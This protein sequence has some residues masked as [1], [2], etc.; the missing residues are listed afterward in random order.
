MKKQ[1]LLLVLCIVAT[2]LNAQV[3]TEYFSTAATGSNLE[4]YNEWYVSAKSADANGESPK[5]QEETLFH[6]GYA[7]SN[8]G[9]VAVLD[10]LVGKVSA[11]QRISTKLITIGSDTLRPVVGQKMYA[12]FL[13]QVFPNSYSSYRDFF[14]WEGSTTSSM[15]RG[16]VFAKVS[17]AKADLQFAVSKNSSSSGGYIESEVITG[18]VGINHL[19]VLCYE[20]I[21]GDNNDIVSLYINPDPT[22]SEAEQ[23]VVLVGTDVQSDYTSTANIK[24][25]LRQRGVSAYIGGIRV[26]TS[27]DAVL[28]GGG[29][30]VNEL[31]NGDTGIYSYGKTIVTSGIGN[32]DVFDLT[33]KKIIS[34]VSNGRLATSL[35]SGLYIVR[36]KDNSG[37]VVSGKVSIN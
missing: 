26:G 16:R 37:K 19:L 27:W 13:V 28:K 9:K 21:G 7:G 25:N 15:T 29:T 35:R 17:N 14:T 31:A 30:L 12:A 23:T 32:V 36:F 10:S 5:I 8:I 11:T 34:K 3:F 22:K 2:T 6:T 24:I 20:S 1:L 4:G 18:G 33:G